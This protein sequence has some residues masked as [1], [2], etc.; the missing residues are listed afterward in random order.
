ML[1]VILNG[2]APAAILLR[3][4]D[5]ILA[6][7]VIVAEEIFGKSIPLVSLGPK[8]F[9]AIAQTRYVAVQGAEVFAGTFEDQVVVPHGALAPSTADDLL[10]SSELSLN[11]EEQAMLQGEDGQ[12][13]AMAMRILA[14][15]GAV[16][17]ATSLLRITQAHIDGCTY[18]GPGGLR[19]AQT[20]AEAGARVAVPTTLNATSVDRQRW[21]ALGVSAHLGEPAYALGDAYLEMGCS[22]SSFTC[23]PYLLDSAP[24]FGEQVAWGE[25]NAVVFA[26]SVLGA[27]TQK[28]ADYLDICAAITGRVP[29]CGAHLDSQRAARVLLDAAALTAQLCDACGDA[30]FPALGYLCGLK[31]EARVP[32]V[33]GLEGRAV[34]LDELKAFSAAFGST[35]SVPMFHMAGITPEAPD[36]AA[37]LAHMPPEETIEL[38]TADL[39]AAWRALD[40]GWQPGR[41]AEEEDAGIQL[42]AVGNPHLSLS[43]CANLAQLCANS[44]PLHPS[45]SLVATLGR[46]VLMQAS[47]AGYARVLQNYGVQFVTDTC[48]CMLGEPVV[49]A[50][51]SALITNSAKYA[52]YAP[53]LVNRRVRFNTMAACIEAA[54]TA[55]APAPPRWLAQAGQQRGIATAA[56]RPMQM[57]RKIGKTGNV[58]SLMPFVASRMLRR[59]S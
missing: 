14:R 29:K 58:A 37:A 54:S 17:G 9:A 12:A 55:R 7:G 47:A 15:A 33:A 10:A 50:H 6:L 56:A 32:V 40:S 24:L 46:E 51:A 22:A 39:A 59:G 36:A 11:E 1:E 27:R 42:V 31:S 28:Y 30:F 23:A 16:D 49:P 38:T 25:S 48:W 20:L 41:G 4:P 3:Q 52:H 57:V 18:I 5:A 13:A 2:V 21:Q 44:A 8:G 19:F 35:A 26:N 34:S 43:E 53:G 45:V